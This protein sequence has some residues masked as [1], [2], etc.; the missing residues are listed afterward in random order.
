MRTLWLLLSALV[1]GGCSTTVV[2]PPP[3][4]EQPRAVF[5]LD[6][7]RHASLAL[8]TAEGA[9]VRYS[10][11]EWGWYAERRTGAARAVAALLVE[12]PAA[13][14]RRRLPGPAQEAALRRQLRVGIEQLHRFDAEAEAVDRLQLELDTLF[15]A[16]P[17]A[18]LYNADFDLEFVPHPVDYSLRYNSNRAVA[19]WLRQL[20]CSVSGNPV[21][22]RWHLHP[23]DKATAE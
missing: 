7:G 21:L 13:L 5:L 19:D 11:G 6:H 8:E 22:S 1:L 18:P 23:T 14:G 10:Y 15:A 2:V 17:T 20:G 3:P 9:L 16:A 12:T 4:P